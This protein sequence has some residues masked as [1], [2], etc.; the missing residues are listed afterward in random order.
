VGERAQ[1]EIFSAEG[2]L[3]KT[4]RP[5]GWLGEMTSIAF[6]GKEVLAGDVVGRLIRR[7]DASLNPLNEIGKDNRPRGFL[8]PNGHIKIAVDAK[9]VIHAAHPGKHRVERY[10]AEGALLGRIGRF[11][12]IDPAGFTGCCN[13]IGLALG[14]KGEVFVTEKAPPRAKI[15]NAEGKLLAVLG[16]TVFDENCKHLDIAADSRGRVYVSDSVKLQVVVFEPAIEEKR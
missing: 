9:G 11:D 4:W 8:I 6:L 3:L 2:K 10:T 14:P 12:G 16:T 1:A 15:L 5:V 7:Y 13:P